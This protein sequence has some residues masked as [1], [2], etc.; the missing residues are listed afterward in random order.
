MD[1]SRFPTVA[2]SVNHRFPSAPLATPAGALD[3]VGVAYSLMNPVMVTEAIRPVPL[4]ANQRV[5]VPG[6]D[7]MPSGTAP[8]EGIVQRLTILRL[9]SMSDTSLMPA[10]L[11]VNQRLLSGPATMPQGADTVVLASVNASVGLFKCPAVDALP[12]LLA[13]YSVK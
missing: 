3:A 11:S 5:L 1:P 10:P 6:P 4:S 8:D 7:V 12:I 13:E 2:L 9:E